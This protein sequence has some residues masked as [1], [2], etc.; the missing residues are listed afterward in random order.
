MADKYVIYNYIE[1]WWAIGELTRTSM[2][3]ALS[4]QP[5][6]MTGGDNFVYQHETG[7]SD[8]SGSPRDGDVYAET[9]VINIPTGGERNFEIRQA[10]AANGFGTDSLRMTFY[11]NQ[12]PMGAERTFGPYTPRADGYV[13]TRVT[14]R[15][16]RI[17]VDA[18]GDND[19]NLG[20]IRLDVAAGARR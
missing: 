10:M 11:T 12:T 13:D 15:D 20:E 5:P 6:L 8:T 17:R 3:P 16:V 19:W 9:S 14:G 1:D 4:G 2:A 7:W 18:L